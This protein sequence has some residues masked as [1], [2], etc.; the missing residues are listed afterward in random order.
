[1]ESDME[2]F[3]PNKITPRQVSSKYL[4][5]Y[6]IIQLFMPITAGMKRDLRR[7]M[8]ETDGWDMAIS[9]ELRSKWVR[10]LWTLEKLK[11]MKFGRVNAPTVG[12]LFFLLTLFI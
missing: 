6:D 2:K 10:N 5:F 12:E 1:M 9:A 11:G 7:V 8:K 4:S 3:V